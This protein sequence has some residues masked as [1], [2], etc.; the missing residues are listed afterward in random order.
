M[1][2]TTRLSRS[3]PAPWPRVS[4]RAFKP[5][6]ST[7]TTT[8]PT[9]V[10]RQRCSSRSS[11]ARP[12]ARVRA[13]VSGSTS[14]VASSSASS[15]RSTRAC[16]RSQAACSR[17]PAAA[18]RSRA[19]SAPCSVARARWRAARLRLWVAAMASTVARQPARR[20]TRRSAAARGARRRRHRASAPPGRGPSRPR[21]AV[22]GVQPRL[23]GLCR[24]APGARLDRPVGEDLAGHGLCGVLATAA[25]RLGWGRH[26]PSCRPRS[27]AGQAR[28]GQR[29]RREPGPRVHRSP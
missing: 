25:Q 21:R 27:M 20:A 28:S 12:A 17:S 2:R 9:P 3:S 26:D 29:A 6:T 18:R 8:S 15:S 23:R 22:G 13:P 19:A 5:I 14:A 7:Y 4:L 10:L 1:C 24:P 11:A 16:T